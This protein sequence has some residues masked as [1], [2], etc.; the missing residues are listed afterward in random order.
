MPASPGLGNNPPLLFLAVFVLVLVSP[1]WEPIV[2]C[3]F[4][5]HPAF[6]GSFESA[7]S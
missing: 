6:Q 1:K 2:F 3:Y 7:F 4:S 5:M